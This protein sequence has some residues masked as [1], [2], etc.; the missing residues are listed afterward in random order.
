MFGNLQ[1]PSKDLALVFGKCIIAHG[2][3][4]TRWDLAQP[5]WASAG[6][7]EGVPGFK[8]KYVRISAR[9]GPYCPM[10]FSSALGMEGR[11]L[12]IIAHGR[13]LAGDSDYPSVV[14]TFS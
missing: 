14:L 2:V 6:K 7:K 10:S 4:G 1:A 3:A 12:E 11:N 13:N 9:N 8:T 5:T